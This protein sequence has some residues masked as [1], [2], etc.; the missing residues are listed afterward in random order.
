MTHPLGLAPDD[1]RAIKVAWQLHAAALKK[2]QK[3]Q[4]KSILAGLKRRARELGLKSVDELRN[5]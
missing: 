4:A 5:L 3:G 2:D 1:V